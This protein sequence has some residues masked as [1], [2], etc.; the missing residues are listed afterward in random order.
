MKQ[1]LLLGT[2]GHIDHGKTAL[3]KALTGVETDR[4]PDEKRRQITIDLGFAPLEL[5]NYQIG[6]VDVPGHERFV[7]N[8]LAG[9]TGVDLALLVV[10]ADDSIKP[11]TREHLEI[12]EYLNLEAGVIA[13]TKCDL[14]EPDWIDLVEAEIRELVEGTRLESAPIV[15]VSA[16]TGQGIDQLRE[17][18][19]LAASRVMEV[20]T[21]ATETPFRMAIDRAFTISGHGTVVTGSVAS[22]QVSVGDELELQPQGVRVRIRGLQS[23][24]TAVQEIERGQRA[25]VNLSGIHYDEIARGQSLSKAGALRP[26]RVLSVSLRVSEQLSRPVKNRTRIRLHVGTSETLGTLS[27]LGQAAIE[28][29]EESFAQVFLSEEV[30]VAWGQPFV[31]RAVS[32][33]E[34]LGGGRILDVAAT[35]I[36]QLTDST[37]EQLSS[38]GANEPKQRA[39]AAAFFAGCRPWQ[40]AD[41]FVLAGVE[42]PD[43]VVDQLI[44]EQL[45]RRLTLDKGK[46]HLLHSKVFCDLCDRI[47]KFLGVEHKRTPLNASVER[48]RLIKYSQDASANLWEACLAALEEEGRIVFRTRGLALANWS[49]ELS[50]REHDLLGRIVEAYREAK[51]QPPEASQLAERF[52]ERQEIV[53]SLSPVAL[54]QGLL[55]RISGDMLLHRDADQQAR[56]LLVESMVDGQQLSLSEIRE[57]LSTSRKFAVPYC[58]YL[59][60]EGFTRREG[61]LRTL[62]NCEN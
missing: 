42:K 50:Q 8:M 52:G 16:H 14:A 47:E 55:V 29:G 24:D 19:S 9:A 61:N 62:V 34:T 59:D 51:I 40:P 6:I 53:E 36:R 5:P 10:A 25:A 4:L 2:A 17:E 38:L 11:Q 41:L 28:P 27:L 31:V 33:L 56:E 48:S 49:P 18:I 12:L 43:Q 15:R 44:E 35:K 32:P 57:L 7:R 30:A 37:T 60:T 20:R 39:A 58:E 3:V 46:V 23:H 13:I 54:E 22:G 45:L 21:S 26:S 1:H